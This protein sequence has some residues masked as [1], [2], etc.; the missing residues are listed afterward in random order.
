[1]QELANI[2]WDKILDHLVEFATSLEGKERLKKTCPLKDSRKACESFSVIVQAREILETGERPCMESLDFFHSWF[3]KLKKN[4]VLKTMELKDIRMFLLEVE[5]LQQTLEPHQGPWVQSTKPQLM[6]VQEPLCAIDHLMTPQG[7]IRSDASEILYKLNQEK[8]QLVLKVQN[9]LDELVKGHDHDLHLQDKYVTNREGRWVIPIK[10]GM[11]HELEGIIHATS[12]SKQTVFMEPQAVVPLNNR[13]KQIEIQIQKEIE[14]LLKEISNF[15]FKKLHD[16]EKSKQV[17]LN[18]DCF[19]ARAQLAHATSA[20][21]IGFSEDFIRLENLRHPLMM[22]N[23][24]PIVA[25]HLELSQKE[26]I[27]ILSGPNA[28][29]KTVLLKSFGLASHMARCGLPVCADSN[30][31]LPFF[32]KILVAVGDNQSVDQNLSTFAGHLKILNRAC[33]AKGP[34]SLILIDEIC[35]S[36]DPDEGSALARS[37]IE[38]Y[39][40]QKAF[41]LI[42]SHLG[43]LKTKWKLDSGIINGSMNYDLNSGQPTY[44]FIRGLAGQSL[45]FATAQKIGILES[46]YKRAKSHLSPQGQ[47]RLLFM[48]E[49]EKIRDETLQLKTQLREKLNRAE[50]TRTEYEKKIKEFEFEKQKRLDQEASQFIE[51]IKEDL[52]KGKIKNLSEI[53]P[54]QGRILLDFPEVTRNHPHLTDHKSHESFMKSFPPGSPVFIENLNRNGIVQGEPNSKG[55]I[56]VL[57]GSMRMFVNWRL[58]KSPGETK[59]PS[60]KKLHPKKV[61]FDNRESELDLR[62]LNASEAIEKLEITLDKAQACQTER[63]RI[64]HGQGTLKKAVRNHLSRS[65]YINGWQVSMDEGDGTTLAYLAGD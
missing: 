20:Q 8:K 49:M 42:T 59:N 57:S 21:P 62:R 31:F 47:K 25:N 43:P 19:F 7:D 15:L 52:K 13:I 50:N 33:H 35:G 11:R 37:F 14:K 5:S 3:L 30:S 27:L 2:D 36:T 56:P 26:K 48:E 4:A 63:V 60:K 65:V 53:H 44:E 9:S 24:E 38:H 46:V 28:G 64:I 55:E 17:M 32:E 18:V 51:K 45:A 58:L 6:P 10:S 54:Q 40:E 12:S 61:I 34:Q 41:G 39:A 1:M 29:G 16:F 23:K 22:I